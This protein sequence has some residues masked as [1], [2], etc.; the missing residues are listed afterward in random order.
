[1][2]SAQQN[3]R[4]IFRNILQI[5][6]NSR[7]IWRLR[8][9]KQIVVR[10]RWYCCAIHGL[11]RVC[12]QRQGRT[13]VVRALRTSEKCTWNSQLSDHMCACPR[14]RTCQIRQNRHTLHRMQGAGICH[15]YIYLSLAAAL[16]MTVRAACQR[17][18][19]THTHTH[20]ITTYIQLC[21]RKR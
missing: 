2:T 3:S 12:A 4:S 21:I 7:W 20:R 15:I 1:M 9:W 16:R 17:G 5:F 11:L 8:I 14:S 13:S 10:V 6:R 19:H 18:A